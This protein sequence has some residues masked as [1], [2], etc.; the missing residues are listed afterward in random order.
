[1]NENSSKIKGKIVKSA[2]WTT[3]NSV[4]NMIYGPVYKIVLA[5]LLKPIGFAYISA[6][7][8]ILNLGALLT[9]MGYSQALLVENSPEDTSF[10]SV[11]WMDI[12]KSTLL[13][14]VIFLCAPFVEFYYELD[15]LK[16][17]VTVLSACVFLSGASRTFMCY[18][19]KELRVDIIVKI[20]ILQ[21]L[22]DGG[23]SVFFIWKMQSVF[24]YVM[25]TL[26][27][28]MVT[29]TLFV[30]FGLRQGFKFRF[31]I[32]WKTLKKLRSYAASVSARQL[33][34]Y[35]IQIADELIIARLFADKS[36]LGFYYFAK[37]LISKP[38]AVITSSVSRVALSTVAKFNDNIQMVSRL[39]LKMTKYLSLV[40]FPVFVGIV[41]TATEFLPL[42]FGSEYIGATFYVQMFC[43]GAMISTISLSPGS[44]VL[45]AVKKPNTL[46][47]ID[48]CVN[49]PYILTLLFMGRNG[50][51][52][53]LIITVSRMILS[54]V[55]TQIFTR[56]AIGLSYV[57]YCR[58]IF[59][60]FIGVV[61]MSI[62]VGICKWFL[63]ALDFEIVKLIV[64]IA[65]GVV[66]YS[67][68][69][70]IKEKEEIIG[71]LRTLQNRKGA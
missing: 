68:V 18:L 61:A 63:S 19:Q 36:V 24:G 64:S 4:L 8:V 56:R 27:S 25:G 23:F 47:Y 32:D 26:I 22:L 37:D 13:C 66:T 16:E 51:I 14:V 10:S 46:L 17:M 54:S 15:G 49:I 71:L 70:I 9:R 35:F 1:M 29:T 42:L 57:E 55:L 60:P 50:V 59:I 31:N 39:F 34:D 3:G 52:C 65:I 33:F 2:K 12:I 58:N 41:L 44:A 53:I 30:I 69:L 38:Q 20:E 67:T 28:R 40:A 7:A 21:V 6:C 45:Y 11:F 5:L 48:L 62:I 43:I